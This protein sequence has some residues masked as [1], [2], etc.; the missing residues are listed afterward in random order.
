MPILDKYILY[1]TSLENPL[2]KQRKTH[3]KQ[4]QEREKLISR[5]TT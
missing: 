2:N 5:V 4:Q 1:K 3:N